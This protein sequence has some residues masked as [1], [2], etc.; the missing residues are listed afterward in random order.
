MTGVE[1]QIGVRDEGRA[2]VVTA[3]TFLR[4][5]IHVGGAQQRAGRVGELARQV[6]IAVK[7]EG[8]IRRMREEIARFKA[9]EGS[10][11]PDGLDYATVPG[12]STEA[13]QGLAEIRP[14]SIGQ[15]SRGPGITPAALSI[16]AVWAHR[17]NSRTPGLMPRPLG[18]PI[19]R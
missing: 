2:V 17:L 11:I 9:S 10:R 6:E 15:A 8:Y 7:Y 13:R 12:L 1:D 18:P 5:L 4:G 19:E 14:R 16:L 3:G